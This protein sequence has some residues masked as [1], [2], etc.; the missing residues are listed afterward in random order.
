[1]F[2]Q[3]KLFLLSV[4]IN[5]AERRIA[6]KLRTQFRNVEGNPNQLLREFQKFKELV[7]RESVRKEVVSER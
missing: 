2:T 7:G 3:L 4:A 1:M 6:I 5:P